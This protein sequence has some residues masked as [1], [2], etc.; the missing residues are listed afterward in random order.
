VKSI[1]SGFAIGTVFFVVAPLGLGIALIESLRTVLIPGVTVMHLL[2]INTISSLS[3]LI[4]LC[5]NG[6]LYSA[7]VFVVLMLKSRAAAKP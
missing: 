4:A 3:R 6:V 5:L 1:L 7:L 2:G